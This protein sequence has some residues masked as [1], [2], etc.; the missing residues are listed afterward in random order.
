GEDLLRT[1]DILA[2][3][4]QHGDSIALV[5]FSGVQYYTGQLF[6]IYNIT[7][8]G[9]QKGCL[10]G[11]DMAHAFANVP[12]Q[13]HDWGVDF[14]CWCTYKYGCSGAGGLGGVFVHSRYAN[15]LGSRERMLGWWSHKMSTRFLMTNELEL[16][17]GANG[18][19]ISNPS[20]MLAIGMLGSLQV[21]SKTSIEALRK[22]SLLLTGYLEYLINCHLGENV[23]GKVSCQLVTPRDPQQRGCQLS[24]K[25][26]C[27]IKSIYLELVKR[28]IAVDKRYPHV[29]RVA[30][31]HLYNSFEDVWRFVDRL[32]ASIKAVNQC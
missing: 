24:L 22:K 19:R 28:G 3:I 11:W 15:D 7:K 31:V 6:E 9:Q 32:L 1:E 20:F 27:D 30:P 21:F 8:A 12:L 14:A 18:F 13:L 17:Q 4:S 5:F 2:Y 10:V 23:N 29:I 25:F 26:N 16:D